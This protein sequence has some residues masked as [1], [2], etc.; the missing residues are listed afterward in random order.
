MKKKI[1]KCAREWKMNKIS[2]ISTISKNRKTKK[3]KKNIRKS[4][5][6]AISPLGPHNSTVE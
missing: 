3:P 4:G 6:R 1:L 5:N 2:K